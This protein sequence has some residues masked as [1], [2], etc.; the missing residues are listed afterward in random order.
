MVLK[1]GVLSDVEI[2]RILSEPERYID[3]QKYISWER[4]FTSLLIEKSQK[5]KYMRYSKSN[6]PDSYLEDRNKNRI[7][8]VIPEEIRSLLE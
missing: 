5:E 4:F 3:S 7:V 6:L 2:D 8:A 1:S